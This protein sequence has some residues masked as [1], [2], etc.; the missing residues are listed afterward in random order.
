MK[1]PLKFLPFLIIPAVMVQVSCTSAD[2]REPLEG[3]NPA[4]KLPGD[5]VA[6]GGEKVELDVIL[7]DFPVNHYGFEEF[8]SDKNTNGVC[9]GS[10]VAQANAQAKKPENGICVSGGNYVPCTGVISCSG[11]NCNSYNT[12]PGSNGKDASWTYP[13]QL[14]YGEYSDACGKVNGVNK[15]GYKSGPDM[16][17]GCSGGNWQNPVFVTK[18]M[19]QETLDYSQC[20]GKWIGAPSDPKHIRGRFC[21]HPMPDNGAC[22]GDRLDE[23][24]TDGGAAR[25]FEDVMEL[26]HVDGN[27]YRIKFDYNTSKDWGGPRSGLDRGYF[28]LDAKEGTYGKQSLNIWCGS[29]YPNSECD[30]RYG[31]SNWHEN[32]GL[33]GGYVENNPSKYGYLWH[34][35]GFTMA[36]SAVFKYNENANDIFEFISNGDMWVFIDS[37]LAVDLGGTHLAAPAKVN[38]KE[39]GIQRGWADGTMHSI[40]FFYANRQTEGSDLMIKLA[41]SELTPSPPPIVDPCP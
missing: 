18:G 21:A 20:E 7:R 26:T 2:V 4:C 14:M 33:A 25:R 24:F 13:N 22:Y 12:A 19:V 27:M 5:V 29:H 41:I 38:I 36:G 9:A 17:P 31:Y 34:N 35:Y 1:N 6:Q 32:P 3:F 11:S 40:N 23:W 28:P 16:E 37:K 39:Y 30:G 10:N 15:R 8:D